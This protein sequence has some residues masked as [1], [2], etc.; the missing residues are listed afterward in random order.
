MPRHKIVY[1]YSCK[2]CYT[3]KDAV[4]I[5]L[6]E[7]V[8]TDKFAEILSKQD[9]TKVGIIRIM[10]TKSVYDLRTTKFKPNNVI[11]NNTK[12]FSMYVDDKIKT[13]SDI[14]NFLMRE[15]NTGCGFVVQP[16]QENVSPVVITSMIT[17]KRCGVMAN[18]PNIEQHWQEHR[19]NVAK[20]NPKQDVIIDRNLKQIWPRATNNM[21][22][23]LKNFFVQKQKA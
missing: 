9:L 19:V 21:P 2:I 20:P 6:P 23:Q 14:K 22:M 18:N 13:A 1:S 11:Y 7:D 12:T 8:D 3:D 4:K 10:R 17:L 5:D 16:G 15:Y